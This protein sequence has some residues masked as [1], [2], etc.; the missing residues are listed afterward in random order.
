MST[1]AHI[2]CDVG[3]TPNA[4]AMLEEIHFPQEL[5]ATRSAEAFLAAMAGAGL[6]APM[7]EPEV[8]L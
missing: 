4:L 5:V 7:P 2:C 1:D 6:D 8:R 3:R